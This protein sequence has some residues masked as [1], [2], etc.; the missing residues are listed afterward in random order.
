MIKR[1]MLFTTLATA[2]GM[3]HAHEHLPLDSGLHHLLHDLGSGGLVAIGATLLVLVVGLFV[4]R[5]ARKAARR[6]PHEG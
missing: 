2:G 4:R 6:S 1:L 3:V 5:E